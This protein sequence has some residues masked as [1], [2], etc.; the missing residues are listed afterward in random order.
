MQVIWI[1]L[2]IVGFAGWFRFG[3]LLG[4]KRAHGQR[5]RQEVIRQRLSDL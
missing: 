2:V 3:W 1:G 4:Q 5:D